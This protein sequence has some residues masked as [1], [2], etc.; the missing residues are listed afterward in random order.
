MKTNDDDLKEIAMK[1]TKFI[2]KYGALDIFSDIDFLLSEVSNYRQKERNY[3]FLGN[4]EK[5]IIAAM[6]HLSTRTHPYDYHNCSQC[7]ASRKVMVA[8]KE[9]EI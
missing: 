2:Q 9:G 7:D 6:R 4:D 8:M 3:G 5:E 1:K